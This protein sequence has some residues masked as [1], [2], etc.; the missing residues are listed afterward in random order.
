MKKFLSLMLIF[1]M[2]LSLAACKNE[3]VPPPS[4]PNTPDPGQEQPGENGNEEEPEPVTER[5]LLYFANSEYVETG[6]ESLDKFITEERDIE[7]KDMSLEEAIV[8]ELMSEPETEGAVTLI[9]PSVTLIDV[10]TEGDMVYVN[11]EG[12]GLNGGSMEESF[13]ISQ[14]VDSL[15]ELEGINKVQFL[16]D[17]EVGESLMGHIEIREPFSN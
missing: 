8:R 13:T 4:E 16:I 5:V 14:I 6:D 3:P 1:V 12:E 15:T 9:P 2:V 10:R 7:V 17:G 11:F